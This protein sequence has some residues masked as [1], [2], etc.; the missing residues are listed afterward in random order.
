MAKR[1]NHYDAAFE[2]Y[3]RAQGIPYVAVDE[4]RRSPGGRETSAAE[5]ATL[6]SVDFIVSPRDTVHR[7]LV[8]VKGRQSPSGRRHKQFWR[9]WSTADE[10]ESLSRWET[11]FG[12]RF[13]ALLV[14]AYWVV[15]D[16]SPLPPEKPFW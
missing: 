6:K 9:N 3:L 13:A 14:F 1:D 11:L 15:E 12:N 16:R 8:D 2:A 4:V 5:T 7:W 10:L